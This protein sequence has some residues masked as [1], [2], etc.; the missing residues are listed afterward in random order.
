MVT[1]TAMVN[2]INLIHQRETAK[3]AD[4]KI[5]VQSIETMIIFVFNGMDLSSWKFL[6]ML[7]KYL[8]FMTLL[9][10]FSELRMYNHAVSR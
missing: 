8:L 1:P 9:Y 10:N 4:S 6:T 7:P 5:V 3:N 2:K